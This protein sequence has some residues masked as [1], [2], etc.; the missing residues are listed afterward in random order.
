M[1]SMMSARGGKCF[2]FSRELGWGHI[3]V[4]IYLKK[5]MLILLYSRD[6]F[7]SD[8]QFES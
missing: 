6:G 7:D 8:S 5:S 4:N 2:D 3:S 1:V